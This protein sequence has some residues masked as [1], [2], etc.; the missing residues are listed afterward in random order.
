MVLNYKFKMGNLC[1]ETHLDGGAV[2]SNFGR[3]GDIDAAVLAATS[4]G[5]G[6]LSN[7]LQLSFKCENLINMDIGSESDPFCI[8][9]KLVKNRW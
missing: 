9:Y 6:G 4:I 1:N 2:R 7:S 5:A 3:G 8:L